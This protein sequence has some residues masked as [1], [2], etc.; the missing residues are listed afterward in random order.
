MEN[1]CVD[2]TEGAVGLMQLTP[3]TWPELQFDRGELWW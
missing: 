2:K 3:D 1:G